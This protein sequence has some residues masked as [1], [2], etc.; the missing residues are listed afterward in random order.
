MALSA[1]F[2]CMVIGWILECG[3]LENKGFPIKH[4]L[5]HD[6]LELFTYLAI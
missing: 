1:R 4:L 3:L 5:A 2:Y 6:H